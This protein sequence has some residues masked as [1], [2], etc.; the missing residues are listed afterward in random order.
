MDYIC[1]DYIAFYSNQQMSSHRR[2]AVKKDLTKNEFNVYL[3]M[4]N[5][6]QEKNWEENVSHKIMISI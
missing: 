6:L 5:M 2:V 1:K 3:K 4:L